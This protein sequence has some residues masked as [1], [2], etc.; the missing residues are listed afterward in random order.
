MTI[1]IARARVNDGF[2]LLIVLHV[3]SAILFLR[4]VRKRPE[5]TW[6]TSVLSEAR[7]P[8]RVQYRR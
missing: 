1:E 5:M 2:R 7:S 4:D 3:F 8:E 6:T